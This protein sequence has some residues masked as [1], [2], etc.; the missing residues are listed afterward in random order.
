MKYVIWALLIYFAWRWYTASSNAAAKKSD[1][2]QFAPE[3]GQSAGT[4]HATETMVRC[5]RCGVHLPASEA[6]TG[7]GSAVFCSEEHRN[8]HSS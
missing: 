1:A 4:V 6:L 8:D 5:A 3:A 2:D 7:A